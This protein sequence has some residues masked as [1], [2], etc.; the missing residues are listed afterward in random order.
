MSNSWDSG[1]NLELTACQCRLTALAP[2][3]IHIFTPPFGT[4][5]LRFVQRRLPL[6]VPSVVDQR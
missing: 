3:R 4:A 5:V 2:H 6:L 1:G